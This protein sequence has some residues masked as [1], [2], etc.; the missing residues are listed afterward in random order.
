MPRSGILPRLE[1]SARAHDP[2]A[3][4][5]VSHTLS[6]RSPRSAWEWVHTGIAIMPE[7]RVLHVDLAALERGEPERPASAAPAAPWSTLASW[8]GSALG[9]ACLHAAARRDPRA[10]APFVIAVGEAV[11]AGLPTAARAAVLSRAPLSGLYAEGHVGGE[12]GARLARVADALVIE[13]RAACAG[14]VLSIE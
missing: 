1:G 5:I 9:L 10:A 7:M 11:R 3:P 4:R 8:G 2:R 6:D 13:G 12:L 14:A